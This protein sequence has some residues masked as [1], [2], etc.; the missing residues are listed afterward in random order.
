MKSGAIRAYDDDK[1]T[2]PNAEWSNNRSSQIYSRKTSLDYKIP[3]K[4]EVVLDFPLN[5]TTE[6]EDI[7]FKKL[8]DGVLFVNVEDGN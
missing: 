4:N 2:D 5:M 6:F 3:G 7:F 8:V 1:S